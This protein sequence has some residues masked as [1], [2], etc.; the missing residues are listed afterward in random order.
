MVIM[1]NSQSITINIK[2][3]KIYY[4]VFLDILIDFI[5]KINW[6]IES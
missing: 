1:E 3:V 2:P 5:T 6:L 4:G